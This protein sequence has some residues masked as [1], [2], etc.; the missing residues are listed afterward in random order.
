MHLNLPSYLATFG[1]KACKRCG[2]VHASRGAIAASPQSRSFFTGTSLANWKKKYAKREAKKAV[3][4]EYVGENAE[5]TT[6]VYAWGAADS[7]A[8]GTVCEILY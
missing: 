1:A 6:T 3:V 7:G 2:C 4:H 5:R 8:L